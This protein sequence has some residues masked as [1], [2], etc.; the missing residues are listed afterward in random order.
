MKCEIGQY[1]H[2]ANSKPILTIV[3]VQLPGLQTVADFPHL[4]FKPLVGFVYRWV[5]TW[6]M[7]E[8]FINPLFYNSEDNNSIFYDSCYLNFLGVSHF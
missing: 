8:I 1:F 6:S 2:I 5:A 4:Q 7:I 3:E